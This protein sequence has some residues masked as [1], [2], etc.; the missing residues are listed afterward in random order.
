MLCFEREFAGVGV[1]VGVGVGACIG[2]RVSVCVC[3]CVILLCVAGRGGGGAGVERAKK[4]RGHV[5]ERESEK[6]CL[7]VLLVG[8]NVDIHVYIC[9]Q[10]SMHAF[11]SRRVHIDVCDA[12]RYEHV[13]NIHTKYTYT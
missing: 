8:M 12:C 9:T 6:D 2:A 3:N 13:H 1:G 10:K 11:I 4:R 5:C 7:I